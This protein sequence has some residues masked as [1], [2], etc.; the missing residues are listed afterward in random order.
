ME[1]NIEMDLSPNEI[2]SSLT[3]RSVEGSYLVED[4]RGEP[5]EVAGIEVDLP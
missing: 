3:M 5:L 4:R 2:W 1:D